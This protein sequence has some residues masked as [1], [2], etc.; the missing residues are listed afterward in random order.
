M[1][2]KTVLEASKILGTPEV[3]IRRWIRDGKLKADKNEDNNYIISMREIILQTPNVICVFNQKGGPGKTSSSITLA[4]Y[5]DKKGYKTL[6]VDLD[7]QMNTSKTFFNYQDLKSSKSLYNFF[8]NKTQVSK[9]VLKYNENID[10][11]PSSAELISKKKEYDIDALDTFVDEF[12]EVF[13]KYQI[14]ILDCCPDV[15]SLS[16]LGLLSANHVVIP[17]VPEPFNYDGVKDAITTVNQVKK[18]SRKFESLKVIINAHEQRTMRIHEEYI[19]QAKDELSEYLIEGSIPNFVGIK[20]RALTENIF[21][22]YPK[23]NPSIK[24]IIKILDKIDTSIFEREI[25]NAKEEV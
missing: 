10:V 12:Y 20:E 4:D 9:L 2:G 11:I 16:K 19:A 23:T 18:F 7:P 13:K 15:N 21:D 24:K 1:L 25:K 8:E 3:S 17:F 22:Q 14:I 6:I 5:Y